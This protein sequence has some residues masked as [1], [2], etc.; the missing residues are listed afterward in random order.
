MKKLRAGTGTPVDT[1]FTG[2]DTRPTSPRAEFDLMT[3]QDPARHL[4]VCRRQ[5][6]NGS[7]AGLIPCF[8][9]GNAVRFRTADVASAI[10]RMRIG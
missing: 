7:M 10:E 3:E 9:L 5:L 2:M 8:K 4:K 6:Y 1:A